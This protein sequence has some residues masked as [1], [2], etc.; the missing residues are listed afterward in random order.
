MMTEVAHP[1]TEIVY[2]HG[3]EPVVAVALVI[4]LLVA[5]I[6][7]ILPPGDRRR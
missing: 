6:A 1:P 4:A 7:A 3:T 2:R 5:V